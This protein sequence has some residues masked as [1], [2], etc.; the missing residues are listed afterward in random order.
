MADAG[1]E[2]AL[3]LARLFRLPLGG[4][5]LADQGGSVGREDDQP[6]EKADGQREVGA[7]VVGLQDD[8][9]E[10]CDADCGGQK[11]V[12]NS[13]AEPVAEDG[14][15]IDGVKQGRDATADMQSIGQRPEIG[16]QSYDPPRYRYAWS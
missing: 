14:P 6:D 7:P 8:D 4:G 1:E 5:Q 9:R 2:D 15:E 16:D 3:R 11:K 12:R 13:E 10:A